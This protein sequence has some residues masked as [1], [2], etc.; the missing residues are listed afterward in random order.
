[1][2]S[3][4]MKAYVKTPS[5]RCL[6]FADALIKGDNAEILAKELGDVLLHVFFY[7][8]IGEEKGAFDIVDVSN[9]PPT[10]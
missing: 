8:K 10:N 1:M 6:N 7:A 3:K 2:P 9:A 5:K 4:P